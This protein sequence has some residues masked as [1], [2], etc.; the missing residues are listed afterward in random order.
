MVLDWDLPARQRR[1]LLRSE[2]SSLDWLAKLLVSPLV[3]FLALGRAVPPI[4]APGALEQRLIAFA[5]GS[6]AF[7]VHV[8]LVDLTAKLLHDDGIKG[9]HSIGTE[10]AAR[11]THDI[12]TLPRLRAWGLVV[13]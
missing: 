6:R 8:G 7:T 10:R 5:V 3:L 4:I 11:A 9:A 13:V 1:V 12:Q 2:D